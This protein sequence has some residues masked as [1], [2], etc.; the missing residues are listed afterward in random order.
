MANLLKILAIKSFRIT[1]RIDKR[2]A[3]L[4]VKAFSSRLLQI[5]TR[6]DCHVKVYLYCPG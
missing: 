3:S 4:F 2:Y 5:S 6:F 1:H